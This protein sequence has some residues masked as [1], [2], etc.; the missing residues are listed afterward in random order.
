M[1]KTFTPEDVIRFAYGEM[2]ISEAMAFR[3]EIEDCRETA[4]ELRSINE[5]RDLLDVSSGHPRK[6]TIQAI[7]NYSR[8][9]QIEPTSIEGLSAEMV[10]N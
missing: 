2:E 5:V 4:K 10:M 6:A 9:L 7:L 8:A 1:Q 3:S